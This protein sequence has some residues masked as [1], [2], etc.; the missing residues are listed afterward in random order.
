MQLSELIFA[1]IIIY[2][3]YKLVFSIIVPVTKVSSAVRDRVQQMQQ[4]QAPQ[5]NGSKNNR[6]SATSKK[7]DST[8][9]DY[10]DFEEIK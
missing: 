6:A 4:E 2:L 3:V 7:K 1:I 10:I 9:S 5:P 8:D